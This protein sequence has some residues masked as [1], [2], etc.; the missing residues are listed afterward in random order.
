M[1]LQRTPAAWNDFTSSF[2]TLK[3]TAAKISHFYTVCNRWFLR[4]LAYY[5]FYGGNGDDNNNKCK[6][7][8]FY[9]SV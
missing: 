3:K 2:K 5:K 4:N 6:K 8:P 1:D 7:Q 9:N